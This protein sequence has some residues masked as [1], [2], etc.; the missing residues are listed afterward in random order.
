MWYSQMH[1]IRAAAAVLMQEYPDK[2]GDIK[3]IPIAYLS[4]QFSDTIQMEYCSKKQVM[5][6]NTQS[7]NGDTTLKILKFY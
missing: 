4:G 5:P 3:E 1:Q 6:F 2:D 7:R